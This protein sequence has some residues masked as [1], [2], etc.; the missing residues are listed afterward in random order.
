M[1]P[2]STQ[3]AT[4][5]VPPCASAPRR[6]G[7]ANKPCTSNLRSTSRIRA[8]SPSVARPLRSPVARGAPLLA[9]DQLGLRVAQRPGVVPTRPPVPG[10]VGR[11]VPRGDVVGAEQREDRAQLSTGLV[12]GHLHEGLDPA[13][14][15][16]V[17]HVRT[18]DPQLRL[19]AVADL[20]DARVLE[21]A[22]EDAAD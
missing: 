13:V 8:R 14:E 10:A 2:T 11:E 16:A 20:E 22:A 21:E 15:V 7:S 18:A 6:S 1:V 4:P 17:H 19:A 3:C 9:L 12:V 5:V